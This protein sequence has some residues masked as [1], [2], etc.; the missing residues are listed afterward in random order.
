MK[1]TT[2]MAR[3]RALCSL[4]I[5]GTPFAS[6]AGLPKHLTKTTRLAIPPSGKALVNFQRPSNWGGVELFAIFDINGKMLIDLP[7]GSEFQCVCDP[8][9]QIFIAWADHVTVV[10]A[11]LAPDKIYDIM[12]DISIGWSRGNIQLIPL[13]KDDARRAKLVEFEKREKKV[14]ALNR[15]KH[16]TDYEEKNRDRIEQI[17]KD[18]LSGEKSDRV[19]LLSKDDCR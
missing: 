8:G 5:V 6:F 17:K 18:F 15:N 11:D 16:V 9:E 3:L 12:I 1:I 19:K 7:G 4:L 2:H 14:V 10:K 13:A